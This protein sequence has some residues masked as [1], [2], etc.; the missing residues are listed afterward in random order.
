M[1]PPILYPKRVF[2]RLLIYVSYMP[3]LRTILEY[4]QV[5][6]LKSGQDQLPWS[7]FSDCS[8]VVGLRTRAPLVFNG[9]CFRGLISQIHVLKTKVPDVG[10]KFFMPQI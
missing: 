2:S 5:S 1:A 7:H 6:V 4:K 3:V 8:S 9:R 10:L